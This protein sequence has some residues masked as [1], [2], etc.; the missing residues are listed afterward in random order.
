MIEQSEM[1]TAV[2]VALYAIA[3][4]LAVIGGFIAVRARKRRGG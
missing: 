2:V 1:G 3:G 4:V